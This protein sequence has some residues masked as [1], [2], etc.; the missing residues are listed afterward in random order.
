LPFSTA[1]EAWQR[2]VQL[3][4][5]SPL[6]VAYE[7]RIRSATGAPP[8]NGEHPFFWAGYMVFD[9][10]VVPHSQEAEPEEPPVLK[11]DPPQQ[12]K[13]VPEVENDE[14]NLD[15]DKKKPDDPL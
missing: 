8:I 7:P 9:A 6:D 3:V 11:I 10:G 2:A 13:A 4:K 5:E 14:P 12:E 1:A 15:E